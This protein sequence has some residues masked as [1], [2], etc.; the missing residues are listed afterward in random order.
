MFVSH[1]FCVKHPGLQIVINNPKLLI[2]ARMSINRLCLSLIMHC[3]NVNIKWVRTP[4]LF[5]HLRSPICLKLQC[6]VSGYAA[7]FHTSLTLSKKGYTSHIAR[8]AGGTQC[9]GSAAQAVARGKCVVPFISSFASLP[10]NFPLLFL[11]R[12][13]HTYSFVYCSQR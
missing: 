11:S 9:F 13:N 10:F 8:L 5:V 1:R 6:S 12:S 7:C 4:G 2:T 3:L